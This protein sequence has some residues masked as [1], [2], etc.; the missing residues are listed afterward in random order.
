MTKLIQFVINNSVVETELPPG[1]VLLDFL[2]RD[3]ILTGTKEVCKEGDCGA[4]SVLLGEYFNGEMLYKSVASCLT[5]IGDLQGKHIVTIEGLNWEDGLNPIQTEF[6]EE[7]ASQCGFCTPGFII[8]LTNFFLNSSNLSFEDAI[9]AMDGNICRCTGY[10]SIKRATQNLVDR[11]SKKLDSNLTRINQLTKWKIIPEYFNS[12]EDKINEISSAYGS[13]PIGQRFVGGGT[14]LFV[15]R[16]D[17]LIEEEL[18][19]IG[20]NKEL[21]YIKEDNGR[22]L[23]GGNTTITEIRDSAVIKK[24][25]PE[26]KEFTNLIASTII[27]N[28]ATIAGN[29]VN[30]SPIGGSTIILLALGTQLTIVC[31]GGNSRTLPLKDFYSGYKKFDLKGEEYISELSFTISKNNSKLNFEKV[32]KRKY[33]DIASVNSAISITTTNKKIENVRV[34]AGGVWA[35]PLL[36]EKTSGFLMKKELT[37]QLIKEAADILVGEIA[38]ISDVRGTAEY[39][40]LLLRQLFYAH[41]IKCYGEYIKMEE[42]V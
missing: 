16:A 12:I 3:R 18:N 37:P 13:F 22:V 7:G 2:R 6:L 9:D 27:R 20:K 42:L 1:T 25:F 5:A 38:P 30:A 26:I 31:Q 8:A 36:L 23:M 39:K 29:I 41:F 32:S 19:F 17:N 40:S 15:Q 33:L 4:C 10:M 28:R 34:S 24:Y 21:S 35:Y 11:Y 14:D